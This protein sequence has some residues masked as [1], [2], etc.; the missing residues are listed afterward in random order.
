[1]T[2][3]SNWSQQP[4]QHMT[5]A[6]AAKYLRISEAQLLR[7]INGKMPGPIPRHARAG[8]RIIFKRAW[9]DQWL[10]ESASWKA[11]QSGL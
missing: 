5:L 10:D 9:L 1:M 2:T 7:L 4:S 11:A 6:E 3:L 8:R